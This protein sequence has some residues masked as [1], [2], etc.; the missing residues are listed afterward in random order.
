MRKKQ[1]KESLSLIKDLRTRLFKAA[2]EID[3]GDDILFDCK[4]SA[5]PYEQMYDRH[6]VS[7]KRSRRQR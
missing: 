2:A 4:G 1:S 6:G 5:N 3:Q 7:D